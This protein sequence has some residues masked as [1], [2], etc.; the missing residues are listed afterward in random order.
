VVVKRWF[1]EAALED[2]AQAED[3]KTM[4]RRE[5]EWVCE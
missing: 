2:I 3:V 5:R 4:E 1:W